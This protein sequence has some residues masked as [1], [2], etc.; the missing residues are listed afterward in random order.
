M[1]LK[2]ILSNIDPFCET[3]EKGICYKIKDDIKHLVIDSK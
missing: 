2:Q 1:N 3:N